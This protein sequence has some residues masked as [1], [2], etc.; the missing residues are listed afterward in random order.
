MFKMTARSVVPDVFPIC[1]TLPVFVKATRTSPAAGAPMPQLPSLLGL[2][3]F[4]TPPLVELTELITIS[5]APSAPLPLSL[6]SRN[7]KLWPRLS[8]TLPMSSVTVTPS[9]LIR[10][11]PFLKSNVPKLFR[12]SLLEAVVSLSSTSEPYRS[13]VIIEA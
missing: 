13:M 8:A 2:M 11:L 10:R 5:T 9:A 4:R 6:E 7:M 3:M 1:V 12:R